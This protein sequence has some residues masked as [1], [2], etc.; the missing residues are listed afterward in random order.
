MVFPGWH[1]I[2]DLCDTKSNILFWMSVTISTAL[3]IMRSICY[4]KCTVHKSQIHAYRIIDFD[5][6]MFSIRLYA[7]DVDAVLL[8]AYLIERHS[9]DFN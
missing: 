3:C 9:S 7:Y 5:T 4:S 6:Q 1:T 8:G 2:Y